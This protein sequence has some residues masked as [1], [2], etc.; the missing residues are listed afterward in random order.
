[1]TDDEFL[2]HVEAR[3]L[4]DGFH[5][6]DHV[7]L[8]WLLLRR[9]GLA[10]AGERMER[11]LRAYAEAA[12]AP[13]KYHLTITWGFLLLIN[14]R[15]ATTDWPSFASA[16]PDLLAWPCRPLTDR[17]SPELLAA[18]TARHRVLLPDRLPA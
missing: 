16:N 11:I 4:P 1:M 18:D 15:D 5:H 3:T 2:G 14:E 6:A 9:H 17:W 10:G 7:R 13:H 8:G 12:D